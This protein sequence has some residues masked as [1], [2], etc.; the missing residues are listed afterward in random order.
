[1]ALGGGNWSYQDK[2]LPGTYINFTNPS[3]VSQGISERGTVAVPL[4]LDWGA[5]NEVI[6]LNSETI[7]DD[8]VKKL[9]YD[10]SDDELIAIRELFKNA[11][12]VL[13]YRLGSSAQ[14]ARNIYCT[15]KYSGIR[16]NDISISIRNS[17]D[18]SGYYWVSTY[19][20]YL[21]VD[22]QEVIS[23]IDLKNND[24]V[25]FLRD[26]SL[27]TATF[28]QLEGGENAQTITGQDY[29]NFLNFMESYSYDILACPTES[30][31]TI[32][33]FKAYT[34][35]MCEET[36]A[37][38]QLVCY[39]ANEADWEGLINIENEVL[40]GLPEWGL[41]YWV[42]G[43][44]S[45][46]QAGQTLTGRTY[47]G[48]LSVDLAYNQAQLKEKIKEGRF[49]FHSVN[50]RASVLR[51]I[52]SLVSFSYEKGEDFA[53]NQTVR[54]CF[55]I[56]NAIASLFNG[57]YLGKVAN[58]SQGRIS[59]W[60]DV[61]KILETLQSARAISEFSTDNVVVSQGES[62]EKVVCSIK[63]IVVAGAMEALYM[64]VVVM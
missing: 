23:A 3:V 9:G 6:R 24:Y 52:N 57:K 14:K 31:D 39:R 55:S 44:Q 28:L 46:A 27:N 37:N 8:C 61:C 40:S 49:T 47:D 64:N 4:I 5:E 56:A 20:D 18:N 33:V 10:Y 19:V 36:G 1:M 42:A 59:F 16:G 13:A 35:R 34:Q 7:F 63:E 38:F 22:S 17:I 53:S 60:N 32:A 26:T 30:Q 2:I 41:V 43:A 54:I 21:L 15:A 25:D 12:E 48:E 29:I 45:S 11:K 50:G 62:K 51:D 58:D